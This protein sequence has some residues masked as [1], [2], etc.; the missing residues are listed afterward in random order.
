M[1]ELAV[2]NFLVDVLGIVTVAHVLGLRIVVSETL[3][4]HSAVV[5]AIRFTPDVA[6]SLQSAVAAAAIQLRR[7]W[8]HMVLYEVSS[9]LLL[10]P[11]AHWALLRL[12]PRV[13]QGPL[14]HLRQAIEW[15]GFSFGQP[16]CVLLALECV[17]GGSEHISSYPRVFYIYLRQDHTLVCSCFGS[18]NR[19]IRRSFLLSSAQFLRFL[20][21]ALWPGESHQ[22]SC[23][24]V[25]AD[26][27]TYFAA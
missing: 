23:W 12:S 14:I 22:R 3:R 4:R 10:N 20:L 11:I 26:S 18:S 16:H 15:P 19:S 8:W 25:K 5:A 27:Y 6:A 24:E 7:E 13:D 2:Q 9:V 17:T 21:S 1:Y